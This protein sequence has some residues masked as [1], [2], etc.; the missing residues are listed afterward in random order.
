VV[1]HVL[2][3]INCLSG[4]LPN[5]EPLMMGNLKAERD[6]GFAPN[7]V[8]GMRRVLRQISVRVA[9]GGEPQADIGANY[10]DYLLATGKTHA[11]WELVNCAFTIGGFDLEWDLKG[12]DPAAWRGYF[13]T[14]GRPAVIVDPRLLRTAEPSVIQVDP[15]RARKE[16]GWAP[17]Q[18]LEV[19]LRDMF[20]KLPRP[21]AATKAVK[22]R[23]RATEGQ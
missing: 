13:R 18:G 8:E 7:Y 4:E 2:R 3:L 23:A 12:D 6:W 14:S 17:S 20:T 11:V 9:N 19:F 22:T 21:A 15:D 16:L 1:T 10:K 5:K